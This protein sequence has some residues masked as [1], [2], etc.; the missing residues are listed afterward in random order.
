MLRSLAAFAAL[1]AAFAAAGRPATMAPD[2]ALRVLGEAKRAWRERTVPPFVVYSIDRETTLDMQYDMRGSYRD[3]VWYRTS[4]GLALTRRFDGKRAVGLLRLE[5]PTFDAAK[6]PGPPTIDLFSLPLL[7]EAPT[8]AATDVPVIGRATVHAEY[9]YVVASATLD[10]A[11]PEPRYHL[12]VR[13]AREPDR[14]RLQELW[15]DPSSYA[16]ERVK[17]RDHLFLIDDKERVVDVSPEAFDMR[18]G[19]TA[20]VRHIAR[21][22]TRCLR[23]DGVFDA[24]VYRYEDVAFPETLPDWYFDEARYGAN[25]KDAPTL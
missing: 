10:A 16:I 13:A 9:D 5:R 3:R 17:A 25:A 2:L 24:T 21:I 23:H 20:G 7:S 6:D 15:I 8:A 4:D 12:V 1:P 14:N 18:M 22:D 19:T 11:G